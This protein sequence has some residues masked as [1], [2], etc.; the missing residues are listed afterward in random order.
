MERAV[1][2]GEVVFAKPL[3]ARLKNKPR[4]YLLDF[5]C[6]TCGADAYF[7]KSGIRQAHFAARHEE[8]CDEASL[9]GSLD[10]QAVVGASTVIIDIGMDVAPVVASQA[11]LA[12]ARASR[13]KN[14]L[15]DG[16]GGGPVRRGVSA[17]LAYLLG[18]PRFLTS[19]KSIS[20]NGQTV[21]ASEFFVPFHELNEAHAGR[22]IG[23]WGNLYS[24]R[25]GGSTTWLNRG[26]A[27][28]DIRVPNS[29]FAE[30]KNIFQF[31]DASELRQAKFLL[32]AEFDIDLCTKVASAKQV[33]LQPTP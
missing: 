17:V 30:L 3:A 8:Y 23:V 29:I 18:N 11:R 33:A 20:V 9:R 31:K 25:E 19:A 10:E 4:P 12:S 14:A 13:N 5:K 28:V 1:Q 15:A 6:V 21:L 24:S 2:N 32:I 27:K 7:R 22:Y 16:G 26:D